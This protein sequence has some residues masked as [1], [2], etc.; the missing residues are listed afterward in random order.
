LNRL[1]TNF[2]APQAKVRFGY[3]V[4]EAGDGRAA[5][6]VLEG[7]EHFDLLFSDIAMPHGLNGPQVAE[8]GL[9]LRPGLKLLFMSGYRE[10]YLSDSGQVMAGVPII[11]KPYDKEEMAQMVA[12]ALEER[13][14]IFGEE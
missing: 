7:R 9:R 3:R 5:Q 8:I 14:E 13:A 6:A 2:S 1:K 11:W 4:I 12:K 10:E